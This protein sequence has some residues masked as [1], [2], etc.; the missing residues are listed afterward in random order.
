MDAWIWIVIGA[1]VVVLVVAIVA[2]YVV[3]QRRRRAELRR[4]SARS[5]NA[6]SRVRATCGGASP[7]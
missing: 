7:T 6:P 2:A 4:P 3:R 1:V 5:M